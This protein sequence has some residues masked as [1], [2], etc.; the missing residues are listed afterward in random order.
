LDANPETSNLPV[1]RRRLTA[2]ER[3]ASIFDAACHVFAERGYESARLGEIA[4][5]AGVS[6]ALIYEH[7]PGKRELYAE[8]LRRGTEEALERVARAVG[9]GRGG[10]ELLEPA[11][12]AFLDFVAERPDIWRVIT[13]EVTDPAIAALDETM[14][15]KAVGAIVE[16]V[17]A[18]PAVRERRLERAQIEQV[19]EMINGAC[20]ALVGWWMANPSVGR[21]EIAAN[22]MSFL[23]LGLE[24]TRRG[25]RYGGVSSAPGRTTT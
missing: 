25:E 17:A 16:L 7:F 21:D 19:A 5:A 3:R 14:H 22:M 4:A 15:R 6:K 20:I 1:A 12:G 2:A 24:R 9:P 11:L 10:A 18:D 8:I 13:Q 23:W